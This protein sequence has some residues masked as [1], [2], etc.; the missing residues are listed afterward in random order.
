MNPMSATDSQ[1]AE[2]RRSDAV[3]IGAGPAGLMAAEQLAN[4][5]FSV[6]VYDAMP[7]IG[8][9][10]LRAGIG[11]LNLTH[12]EPHATFVTRYSNPATVAGW[13]AALD[14]EG[15]RRWAAE[16]GSDSFVGSSGRVFP[17][18]KKAAPLLR[19]WL[20]RLRRRGVRFWTRHRWQYRDAEGRQVLQGP[21][22]TVSHA[23]RVCVF[24]MGGGSWS[25]LGSDGTWM[26]RFAEMG[27]GCAPLKPANCGFDTAWSEFFAARFAGTPVKSVTLTIEQPGGSIWKRKGEVLISRYGLEGSLIYAAAALLRDRIEQEGKAVVRWDL[28][29]DR[30]AAQVAQALARPRNR[31]SLSNFLRKRLGLPAVKIGL[32]RE[33]AGPKVLACPERLA[34]AVKDLPQTLTA[35]RPID[36]AIST[37]GGVRLDALHASLMSKRYP[38]VFCAG[39]MLDWEA[40][41]GGY[42]LTA[43][44]ASGLVAGRSAVAYLDE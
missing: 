36:E 6:A 5:G 1:A 33:L 18:E 27:I 3:V 30:S 7:S 17:V 13:L 21:G 20:S 19:A 29:P 40:P 37:A 4:A 41:T 44:F 42:L 39:E 23:S 2:C 15:L 12:A 11:G 9:K 24:A 26:A 43:C 14:A 28:L 34:L 35:A 8:R 10:F 25:R 31:D 32:L 16:L 38:G 22:G